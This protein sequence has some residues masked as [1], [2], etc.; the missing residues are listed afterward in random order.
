ME[1]VHPGVRE[2]QEGGTVWAW[3]RDPYAMGCVSWPAPGDVL[4]FLEPLQRSWGRVHFA[5]EHTTILRST[6][7]GAIR[8]GIRAAHEVNEA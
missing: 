6:M 1:M 2:H 7:E 5:G 4:R 3:S 8:S